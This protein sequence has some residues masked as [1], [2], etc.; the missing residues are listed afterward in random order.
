MN[1]LAW[2]DFLK[3]HTPK[4]KRVIAGIGEDCAVIANGKGYLLLSSDLFIENVHFKLGEI[5]LK[6]LGGRAVARAFSDVIA[7]AGIPEFLGVSIGIPSGITSR[8]LKSIYAGIKE[9]CQDLNV[10]FVGGDTS[11]AKI[12]FMDIWVVGK[13]KKCI[14]RSTARIGDYVFV[15]GVLG[16]LKFNEVFKL[17][18]KEIQALVS[19]FKLNAMIDISDGFIL[20]LWRILRESKKGALIY[21]D[22]I[23][24]TVSRNDI[25]RGEDYELIFTVSGDQ[26]INYLKKKYFL[27]GKIKKKSFGYK[28]KANNKIKDIKVKGFTHF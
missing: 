17:R 18:V 14:L 25:F 22:D 24:V 27:V 9:Y 13:A 1:E 2:V 21:A 19:N 20:D 6:N 7:C 11:R 15:T 3:K 16:K 28:I 8:D 4:T 26:D 12:L 23:P 5:S 10:S